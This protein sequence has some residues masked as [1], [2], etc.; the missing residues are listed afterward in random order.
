MQA[1]D[2]SSLLHVLSSLGDAADAARAAC[3][4]KTLHVAAAAPSIWRSHLHREYGIDEV[5]ARKSPSSVWS[6]SRGFWGCIA[7]D[8]AWGVRGCA[9]RAAKRC[10]PQ[11]HT[12]KQSTHT[13]RH[14]TTQNTHIQEG[15]RLLGAAAAADA[16]TAFAALKTAPPP[17]ALRFLAAYTNGGTDGGTDELQY[18]ADSAFQPNAHSPHCTDG[19]VDV[20][21]VALLKGK[22]HAPDVARAAHRAYMIERCTCAAALLFAPPGGAR[23]SRQAAEASAARMLRTWSTVGIER[24]FADLFQDLLLALAQQQQQQPPL[25]GAAAAAAALAG[26]A[27]NWGRLLLDGV[28]PHDVPR[29]TERLRRTFV[30]VVQRAWLSAYK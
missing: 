25:G 10:T 12:T 1:L 22:P 14:Y 9:V 19:P 20:S 26:G 29:E 16:K 13:T 5:S 24:L 28:E 3:V 7:R 6:V 11:K 21:V 18:W 17:A 4:S 30:G 2:S 27:G 23:H 15:L 8:A